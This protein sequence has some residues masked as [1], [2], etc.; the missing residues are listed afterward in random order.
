MKFLEIQ[1]QLD[2]RKEAGLWR[3]RHSI[4]SAQGPELLSGEESFLNFASNDYLGLANSAN[5]KQATA[6]AIEAF[7]FGS[8]ASH[9]ICGHQLPHDNLE[10]AL[11]DFVGREAALTFSSGYMANL[12][13]LQSLANK[14][15]LIIADKLNHASLID[16][17]KLSNAESQRYPHCD[18]LA[19]E[20]RLKKSPQNKFVVT[21]SVFS[22]DGDIAPLPAIVELCEHYNAILIVDDAHGFGVIGE[23]GKGCIEHF[24]LNQ[25][26][27]PI[28]MCTLGKALGG[29]G[30]FVS[31]EKKLIDFLM[32]T[33]RSYI[34]T[35][36]M[37]AVVAS[38]NCANLKFLQDSPQIVRKLKQNITY[39]KQQCLQHGIELANS[40]TAI[41]PIFV[42]T[43]EKLIQVNTKLMQKGFLVGAIRPPTVPQ[44]SARL[45]ITLSVA[46]RQE[47]IDRLVVALAQSL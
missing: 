41:Q 6:E 36:A 5:A 39:F 38:A 24:G 7:G 34:Y 35:T 45:R 27:L 16:G 11:A 33:A 19:L 15:D 37:P 29:F 28:L 22:M 1:R 23:R 14:G 20:N 47:H 42:G 18:L 46:H 44:N 9:L 25:T 10:M 8:G 43:N 17:A 26:Q 2:A 31:G 32:Q 40:S 30:A 3:H 21:D 12:A 4:A 13:I